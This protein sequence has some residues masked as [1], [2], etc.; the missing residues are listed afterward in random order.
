MPENSMNGI[1]WIKHAKTMGK[2][3]IAE[4]APAARVAFGEP[5]GIEAGTNSLGKIISILKSIG[6]DYVIDTSLGADL[7][8]YYE[9]IEAMKEINTGPENFLI[10]NSCCTGWRLYAEKKHPELSKNIS[11]LVSPQMLL[12][13]ASKYFFSK[14][15]GI[16]IDNIAVVGIMPC[17]Q[18]KE[19]TKEKMKNGIAYV[20]Y[21]ITTNELAT[22]AKNSGIDFKSLK[23][24]SL[25][26]DVPFPSGLGLGFGSTGGV[27]NSLL[28]RIAEM[29]NEKLDIETFDS[30]SSIKKGVASIGGKKF[31]IAVV[32]GLMNFEKIYEEIKKGA[33]YNFIEVMMCPFGCVGGAGQPPASYNI[34]KKRMDG[35]KRISSTKSEGPEAKE[36]FTSFVKELEDFNNETDFIHFSRQNSGL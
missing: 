25:D 34:I 2:I 28:A 19:E 13:G 7:T 4:I 5:F 18:K 24:A 27:M 1:E 22:W 36:A 11:R 17:I 10:L 14:K 20:D 3:V 6:V 8:S 21:I 30:D 16:K 15:L 31:K 29:C 23:E 32:Y 12:G 35:L 26:N 9:A 33:V